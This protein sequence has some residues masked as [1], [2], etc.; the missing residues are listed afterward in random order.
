MSKL[1]LFYEPNEIES[2]ML[3]S[4]MPLSLMKENIIAQFEDPLEYRKKDH[5]T[6]FLNMYEYSKENADL[7][8]DE[9]MD[10]VIE[11]RDDFYSFMQKLFKDYLNIGFV[12]FDDESEED[13]DNLI[14]FTYR[15]FIMNIKKNFVSYILN[16]IEDHKEVLMDADDDKKKDVTSMSFKKEITDPTDIYILSNLSDIIDMTLNELVEDVLIDEFFEKCGDEDCLETRIVSNAFENMKITGNFVE[17]Y[18]D[19]LDSDF[20]SEIES[21]VRNKILKRYKKK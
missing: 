1:E 4:E 12:D 20:K 17:K 5:I 6:T 10:N 14:H 2:D 9:E 15:Y 19:M 3:L 13:Q 21:K 7:S 8:E 18:V 16:W 11:L